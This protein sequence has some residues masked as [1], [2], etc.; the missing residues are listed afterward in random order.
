MPTTGGK[1]KRQAKQQIKDDEIMAEDWADVNSDS[2][3]S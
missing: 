3:G 1:K 2:D